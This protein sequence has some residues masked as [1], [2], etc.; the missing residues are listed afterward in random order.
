M[1]L[2]SGQPSETML[3]SLGYSASG[4]ILVWV[5]CAATVAMVMS[6]PKLHPRVMSGSMI[7]LQLGSV[8]TSIAQDNTGTTVLKPR[9]NLSQPC[10]LPALPLT[11]Y[12][13]PKAG[14]A[15]HRRAWLHTQERW[16]HPSSPQSH[17]S[18]PDGTGV[19]VLVPA[20]T[21]VGQLQWDWQGLWVHPIHDLMECVKG[22][23][24]WHHGSRTSMTHGNGGISGS[25]DEAPV[26]MM[27]PERDL[28]PDQ[29]LITINI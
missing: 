27:K 9:A 14:L 7:L 19:E 24:M 8:L 25:F 22:L 28:E 3:V 26:L 10:L 6:K 2:G 5:A 23:D 13:N 29:K 16:P 17:L 20:P 1:Y 18:W 21:W 4:V 11:G 15:L 12:C